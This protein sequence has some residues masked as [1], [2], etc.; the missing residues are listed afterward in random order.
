MRE[1]ETEKISDKKEEKKITNG[2][3]LF[4]VIGVVSAA[5]VEGVGPAHQQLVRGRLGQ[6]SEHS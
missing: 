2:S 3:I 6:H 5:G 1:K 4:L